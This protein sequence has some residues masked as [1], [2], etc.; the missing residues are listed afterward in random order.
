MNLLLIISPCILLS[1]QR[2]NH[3]SIFMR[4]FLS[5]LCL[6]M[7]QKCEYQRFEGLVIHF[8][9]LFQKP[10]ESLEKKNSMIFHFSLHRK[11]CKRLEPQQI[12][13]VNWKV[14]SQ[15][16]NIMYPDTISKLIIKCSGFIA[17]VVGVQ[18]NESLHQHLKT[19][20]TLQLPLT[21]AAHLLPGTTEAASPAPPPANQMR[22]MEADFHFGWS[23]R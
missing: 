9:W 8:C 5:L 22:A 13:T 3:W 6:C 20:S 1:I 12:K 18:V 14:I 10:R 2:L 23:H 21:A 16:R 17:V 19:F 4:K 7:S 11:V 15:G